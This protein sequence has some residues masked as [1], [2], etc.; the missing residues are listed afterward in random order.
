LKNEK[1]I[2]KEGCLQTKLHLSLPNEI[3]KQQWIFLVHL[4]LVMKERQKNK[5]KK[6]NGFNIFPSSL[7]N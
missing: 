5:N 7:I 2:P 1:E 4:L 3:C 6:I